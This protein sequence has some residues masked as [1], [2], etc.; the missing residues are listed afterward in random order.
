VKAK[1]LQSKNEPEILEDEELADMELGTHGNVAADT[2]KASGT[3]T[4]S[5]QL[6]EGASALPAI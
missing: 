5:N 1:P 2:M 6:T 4:D 3:L